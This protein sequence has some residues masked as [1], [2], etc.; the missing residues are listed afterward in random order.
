MQNVYDH[1]LNWLY[2]FKLASVVINILSKLIVYHRQYKT[3][4]KN[5][6]LEA[7]IGVNL[8]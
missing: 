1:I 7:N 5:Y 2:F 6:R 3:V 8:S 4:S